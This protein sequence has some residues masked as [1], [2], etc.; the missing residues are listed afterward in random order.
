MAKD[1]QK[2]VDKLVI[3]QE[4]PLMIADAKSPIDFSIQ[5]LDEENIAEFTTFNIKF[6]E[7]CKRCTE[8]EYRY[9]GT[10]LL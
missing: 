5:V 2:A 7:A 9:S 4:V 1:L 8:T 3:G 10:L 6:N